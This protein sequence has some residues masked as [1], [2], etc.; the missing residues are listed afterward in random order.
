VPLAL[1]SLNEVVKM[2]GF[3]VK[4]KRE[5]LNKTFKVIGVADLSAKKSN[6][7]SSSIRDQGY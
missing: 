7:P 3:V 5:K 2:F 4:E 1:Y 6:L